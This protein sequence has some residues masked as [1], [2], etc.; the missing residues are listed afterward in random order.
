MFHNQWLGDYTKNNYEKFPRMAPFLLNRK[1]VNPIYFF[2]SLSRSKNQP[3]SPQVFSDIA[4][5][6]LN[7]NNAVNIVHLKDKISAVTAWKQAN[8]S[9]LLLNAVDQLKSTPI[10][11]KPTD[12][13]VFSLDDVM[14][15]VTH[16]P[17]QD[18]P[19]DSE[20]SEDENGDNDSDK[21][22]LNEILQ[23]DWALLTSLCV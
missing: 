18:G 2:N 17:H 13:P 10:K 11:A 20:L 7:T 22:A 19:K 3:F 14:N 12:T 16:L 9:F 23:K 4:P 15:Q 8:P 6:V 5:I 1:Q 21:A